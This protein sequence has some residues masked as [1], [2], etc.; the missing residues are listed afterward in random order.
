M[1]WS[2]LHIIDIMLW[3]IMAGSVMYV[4][5]FAF[6]SLFS[7]PN[8]SIKKSIPPTG[9]SPLSGGFR[10]AS[11]LILYPAY[12]EDAVIINSIQQFLY[13]NY[14][15]D[16]YH[17]AVISD[18]M[19]DETNAQLVS[20]SI[21]LLLPSFEKSS[22]ARAL[23]YAIQ[24]TEQ[25]YDHVV[26]LDADNVVR[27]D[28]LTSLND[29]CAQGY[30]AIQCHR[31]AK[32]SDNDIAVLDGVSE[33]INNSLFRRAHNFIGMSSALI[34]SGMCFDFHWFKEHVNLLNSA[35]EDRELEAML[36]REKVFIKFEDDIPVFDEKVS[37][38]NNFQRQRL[39]WMTGQVQTLLLMLPYIPKAIAT[40]NI[41]YIDKTIQQAL[42]P[43]SMLLVLTLVFAV[44]SS[45]ISFFILH[46]SL[47]TLKWWILFGLLSVSLFIAMPS[48]LRSRAVFS[49]L[50]YLPRLVWHMITNMFKIDRKNKEFIHTTH[51]K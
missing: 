44:V 23:Q 49:R 18:H 40:G 3:L 30:K 21:T 9:K 7:H 51:T 43:R 14:P 38:S 36:M 26:I 33:E 27:P 2:V 6:V 1:I 25:E 11:F 50:T 39:R 17:L 8:H 4:A 31:C 29:V 16:K 32:N 48:A 35:V 28:F 22:K 34:G 24:K 12:H 41:N 19:E 46:S 47:F 37:N 45:V 13:S 5:F 20:L 15:K 42:I 10:E